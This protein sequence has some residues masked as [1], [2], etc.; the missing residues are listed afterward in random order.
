MDQYQVE[1]FPALVRVFGD[2]IEWPYSLQKLREDEPQLSMSLLP[3]EAEIAALAT[4]DPPIFAYIPRQTPPPSY[5]Q[6]LERLEE[7]RPVPNNGS[8]IQSWAKKP[9]TEEE[10]NARFREKNPPN[11]ELFGLALLSGVQE[12]DALLEVAPKRL[13]GGLLLGL[14]Q[15]TENKANIFL[16]AWSSARRAGMA[17]AQLVSSVKQVAVGCHLPEDFVNSID[18]DLS[19]D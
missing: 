19:Q 13:Y 18:M 16:R 7:V 14:Q 12:L 6:D 1:G 3:D 5:N 2:K 15:A 11:W 17:S 4:L 8:W 10:R 9:L